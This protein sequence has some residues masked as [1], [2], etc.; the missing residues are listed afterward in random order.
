MI[1]RIVN[2][3]SIFFSVYQWKVIPDRTSTAINDRIRR[4]QRFTCDR[5]TIVYLCVVYGV[6]NILLGWFIYHLCMLL[7]W[8]GSILC[9]TWS[10]IYEDSIK[11][12]FHNAADP[13]PSYHIGKRLSIVTVTSV[14]YAIHWKKKRYSTKPTRVS[15]I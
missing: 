6:R 9:S 4:I 7:I 5:I 8:I 1:S 11:V 10:N 3:I 12:I 2:K 15:W 14:I 13:S